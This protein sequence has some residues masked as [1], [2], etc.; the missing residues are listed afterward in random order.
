MINRIR[1][2]DNII[3]ELRRFRLMIHSHKNKVT[4]R[5]E[6]ENET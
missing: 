3:L 6:D 5:M 1:N 4:K 2:L